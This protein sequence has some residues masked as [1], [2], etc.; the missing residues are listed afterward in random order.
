MR[1]WI[2]RRACRLLLVMLLVQVAVAAVGQPPHLVPE[3]DLQPAEEQVRPRWPFTEGVPRFTVTGSEAEESVKLTL[4]SNSFR[5]QQLINFVLSLGE[6]IE[7]TAQLQAGQ[8]LVL[9]QEG[10]TGYV[11]ISAYHTGLDLMFMLTLQAEPPSQVAGVEAVHGLGVGLA[12]QLLY[13]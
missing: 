10:V 5:P 3:P 8:S 4:G 1:K 2:T 7:A 12:D 13:R 9:R 6:F 11:A